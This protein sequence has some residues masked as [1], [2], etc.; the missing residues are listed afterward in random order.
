MSNEFEL[1][2]DYRG[3]PGFTFKNVF[4]TLVPGDDRHLEI[5]FDF[6]DTAAPTLRLPITDIGISN[7]AALRIAHAML[8]AATGPEPEGAP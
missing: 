3:H 7:E 8:L 1:R 5:S 4:V 2:C 6:A